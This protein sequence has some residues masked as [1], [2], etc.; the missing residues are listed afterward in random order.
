MSDIGHIKQWNYLFE[1]QE[2]EPAEFQSAKKGGRRSSR[3]E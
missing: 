3:S 1:T 2:R